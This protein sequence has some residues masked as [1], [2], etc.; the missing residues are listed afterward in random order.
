M[1]ER[2]MRVGKNASIAATVKDRFAVKIGATERKSFVR[3]EFQYASVDSI[4]GRRRKTPF[5]K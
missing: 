5:G 3:N 1:I 2:V 4:K